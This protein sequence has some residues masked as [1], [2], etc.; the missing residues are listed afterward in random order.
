VSLANDRKFLEMFNLAVG[1][2]V[3]LAAG[4][5]F[6]AI[7]LQAAALPSG[8]LRMTMLFAMVG[9]LVFLALW[10]LAWRRQPVLAFGIFLGVAVACVGAAF[11]PTAGI[12]HIPAWLPALPVAI[13]ATALLGF[14][15]LAW[16]WGRSE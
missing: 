2:L 16:W 13:I 14:G 15:I 4:V 5:F 12:Q 3:G 6:L 8:S 7:F 10:G 1:M 9:L 11:V